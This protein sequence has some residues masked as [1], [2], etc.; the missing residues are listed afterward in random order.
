MKVYTK[1]TRIT[2]SKFERDIVGKNGHLF[3][4]N[5]DDKL[6]REYRHWYSL[7]DIEIIDTKLQL[8]FDT[9]KII[10]GENEVF[11]E[12]PVEYWLVIIYKD[13]IEK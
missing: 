11:A 2:A 13:K 4:V 9:F 5:I 6:E 8:V 1:T 3:P 7:E 10:D 12:Y